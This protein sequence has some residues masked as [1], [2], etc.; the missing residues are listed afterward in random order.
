MTVT[1]AAC[2]PRVTIHTGYQVAGRVAQFGRGVMEDVSRRLI[3]QMAD[4]IKSNLE[5]ESRVEEGVS[6]PPMR[7]GGGEAAGGAEHS[8]GTQP[9][10]Q[11]AKPINAFS[12]MFAVLWDRIR[13]LFGS[14]PT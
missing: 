2:A 1:E 12:L 8:A 4:C 6:S 11:S 3:G 9:S 5:A 7:G 10:T 13:R 14:K